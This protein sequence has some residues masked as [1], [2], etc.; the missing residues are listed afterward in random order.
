MQA[1]NP[2]VDI[3]ANI[4]YNGGF[5]N[6]HA[7]L[8]RAYTIRPDDMK[9]VNN[10][11]FEKWMLVDSFK[12]RATV[13]DYYKNISTAL[14]SQLDF[15]VQ[16]VLSFID[17]DTV[18]GTNALEA[19]VLAREQFKAIRL[20]LACQTL[21]GV[22]KREPRRLI[23][24]SLHLFDVVGSLPGADPGQEAKH[25]DIVIRWAKE[26]GKR[27]HVHVDQ[28][29]SPIEM[30][31]ELLA[32]KVMKH[33]YEGM[34]TAVHSISLACHPSKYRKEVS[35]MAKDA[36]LS[37]ITCPGAWI[38]H[39]R[40]E[41]MTPT[42]NSITPV[43]EMLEAGLMVG[44]GTDNIHD[45]YKPFSDGDMRF[46]ARLLMEALRIQ[47]PNIIKNICIDNGKK[48]IGI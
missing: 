34:V 10:H 45:L 18:C 32:R 4:H 36:G 22:I 3:W 48:I 12:S 5:V 38:D 31:T 44:L 25:L 13:E 46:E 35:R 19:A 47:D 42:H 21:K 43:E 33:G 41:T 40:N 14:N 20:L 7:H 2:L 28:L 9:K 24:N 15:G 17:I 1:Y 23:E 27:L 6:A 29:N 39:N 16:A 37:F 8:D 30:E 11:L 26:T